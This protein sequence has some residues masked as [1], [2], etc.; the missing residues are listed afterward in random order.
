MSYEGCGCRGAPGDSL[1]L[2][3]FARCGWWVYCSARFVLESNQTGSGWIELAET[4]VLSWRRRRNT[5]ELSIPYDP[6]HAHI[7]TKTYDTIMSSIGR[8]LLSR[9]S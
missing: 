5:S 6:V 2:A 9:S 4:L 7:A 1:A 8:M 3:V